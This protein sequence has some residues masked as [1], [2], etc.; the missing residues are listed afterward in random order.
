MLGVGKFRITLRPDKNTVF[1][2]PWVML[3]DDV[4]VSRKEKIIDNIFVVLEENI[5]FWN[6]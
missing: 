2:R 5:K 4:K 3:E 6:L 1:V